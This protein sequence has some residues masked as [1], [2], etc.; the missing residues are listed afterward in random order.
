MARDAGGA[1]LEQFGALVRAIKDAVLYLPG[2]LRLP[3]ELAWTLTT[4][5]KEPTRAVF[6]L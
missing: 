5:A 1:R 6:L 2:L 4:N 3:S